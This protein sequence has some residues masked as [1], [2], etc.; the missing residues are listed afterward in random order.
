M[1][2]QNFYTFD[3]EIIID[4]QK[5]AKK[6][7]NTHVGSEYSSYNILHNYNAIPKPEN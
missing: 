6:E 4:S 2:L 3:S 7:K 1:V 5:L